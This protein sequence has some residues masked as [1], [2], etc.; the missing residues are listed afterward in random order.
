[1]QQ[2]KSPHSDSES[3]EAARPSVPSGIASTTEA[4][5]NLPP[6]G[7]LP[8]RSEITS[9]RYPNHIPPVYSSDHNDEVQTA[10]PVAPPTSSPTPTAPSPSSNV[11]TTSA[12]K[13]SV[14]TLESGTAGMDGTSPSPGINGS[15][16]QQSPVGGVSM[17]YPGHTQGTWP[18]PA[19]RGYSYASNNSASGGGY[20]RPSY[21]QPLA[22]PQLSQF[23][24]RAPTSPA[25]GEALP[26]TSTFQDH[27]AYSGAAAGGGG[28][29]RGGSGSNGGGAANTGV[30]SG[31]VSFGST[32]LN[33]QHHGPASSG[34]A[35]PILGGPG[36]TSS[37]HPASQSPMG[38]PPTGPEGHIYR[39]AS[40]PNGFYPPSSSP[41]QAAF[42]FAS[43][44][45]PSPT[46][47]T[48]PLP[49]RTPL[50][51]AMPSSPMY[52]GPSR[53]NHMPPATYPQY[54]NISGPI[55]SNVHHPNHPMATMYSHSH[56]FAM[57][58][59]MYL[60]NQ[61]HQQQQDRPFKCEQCPQGFN[62]NH[63][64]KRH[65]RIHLAIK[66]FPCNMCEK[67]FSRKDALKRHKMVKGCDTKDKSIPSAVNP[68]E[69]RESPHSDDGDRNSPTAIKKE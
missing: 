62:R 8:F 14:L 58:Q 53:P 3:D 47:P 60:S 49:G 9:T 56:H 22:S 16:S 19:A 21:S 41:Q 46:I 18:T 5:P 38:A 2:L 63:D 31:A 35:L 66:P 27:A 51:S 54:T 45:S 10:L 40:T 43:Q 33:T 57:H 13:S 20:P 34:L 67:S 61:P 17:Y 64:L 65:A 24:T 12:S 1:M 69:Q 6:F 36:Q 37:Q 55:L 7:G 50:I 42:S 52:P 4:A 30:N 44:P 39:S 26:G 11:S 29:G 15:S 28:G 32:T 48:G 25:N 68:N 59:N 23:P